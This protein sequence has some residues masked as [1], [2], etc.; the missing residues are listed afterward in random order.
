MG[1][2]TAAPSGTVAS[3]PISIVTFSGGMTVMDCVPEIVVLTV[4]SCEAVDTN[5][6]DTLAE[7]ESDEL[8]FC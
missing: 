5:V 1:N 7:D 2:G 8:I 4:T 3:A 6:A